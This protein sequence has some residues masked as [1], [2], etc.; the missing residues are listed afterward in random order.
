MSLEYNVSKTKSLFLLLNLLLSDV[1][2][3]LNGAIMHLAAQAK[4]FEVI[5]YSHNSKFLLVVPSKF[6]AQLFS[7]FSVVTTT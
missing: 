6:H 1:P 3:L 7:T 2:I 5:L 4:S